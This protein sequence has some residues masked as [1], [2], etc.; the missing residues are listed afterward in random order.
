MSLTIT[1]AQTNS[2]G[3]VVAIGLKIKK[4]DQKEIK[5]TGKNTSR[6]TEKMRKTNE[7]EKIG[8]NQGY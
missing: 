7:K 5:W 8:G 4:D 2:D 1:M 6:K 3:D